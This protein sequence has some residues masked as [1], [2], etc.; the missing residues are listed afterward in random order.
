MA[1]QID[2][3]PQLETLSQTTTDMEP[4]RCKD[5]SM[6]TS[7]RPKSRWLCPTPEVTPGLLLWLTTPFLNPISTKADQN[8]IAKNPQEVHVLQIRSK[9]NRI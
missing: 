9:F 7:R 6:I 4:T 1:G 3:G 5:Q 2:R 8:L